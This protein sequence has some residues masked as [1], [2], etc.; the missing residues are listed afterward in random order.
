MT[1]LDLLQVYNLTSGRDLN[2][3]VSIFNDIDIDPRVDKVVMATTILDECGAMRC[4]YDT[5]PTFKVFSDNFFAKYKESIS[6]ILDALEVEYSPLESVNFTWTEKTDISQ[7]M[8]TDE[9][10]NEDRQK[11][12]TGS[13]TK[14]NTGTS[15]ISDSGNVTTSTTGT[16]SDSGSGT[17]DNTISAMNES[18][19]QPDSHRTTSSTN[20]NTKNL[21]EQEVRNT[22]EE[23]SD[24]LQ[25]EIIDDK[26]ESIEANNT[27]QKTE[28]LVWDELDTHTE[29]GSK[30]YA[31]Q[32]LIEKEMKIRNFSIY[33]WIAK[34][35]ASELFLLVY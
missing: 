27:R 32:D 25:E 2:D 19:Y 33:G 10:V 9:N 34:K 31:Y 7:N 6:R 4:I 24:D 22:A 23:R 21:Q 1:Y 15:T 17:E 11:M 14:Q 18:T 35:Y 3:I 30:G 13:Q 29:K 26:Q 5:S 20:T 28:A 16:D 12:N 8:D